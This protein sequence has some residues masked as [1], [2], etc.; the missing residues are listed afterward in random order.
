VNIAIFGG[1][2][3]PIHSGHLQ[4]AEVAARKFHLDRVLFVATGRPPHKMAE[5]LT[6]FE[7]R[8]AMVALACAGHRGFIPSLLEAPSQDGRPS[9]SIETVRR[10]ARSLGPGDRLYFILGADA[11][12]DLPHWKDYRSLLDSADFIVIPRPGFDAQSIRKAASQD[13]ARA[14]GRQQPGRISLGR[15][16]VYILDGLRLPWAS[17]E[18]REAIREDHWP[19]GCVTPLVKQY[20]QKEGLYPS[21]GSSDGRS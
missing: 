10:V 21:P 1:T 2:F 19:A 13:L 9:Y 14:R 11:F 12:L 3:D 17:R 18:I 5:Q 20:I 8:Y 6:A 15:S 7:H 4:A 16:V